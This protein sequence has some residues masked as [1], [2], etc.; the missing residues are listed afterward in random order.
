MLINRRFF[1]TILAIINMLQSW[2][3]KLTNQIA[4]KDRQTDI[5]NFNNNN[6]NKT[7]C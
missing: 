6:N 5:K 1:K 4:F 7:I 2:C 3:S